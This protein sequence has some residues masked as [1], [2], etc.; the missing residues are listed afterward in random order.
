MTQ[1]DDLWKHLEESGIERCPDHDGVE[2]EGHGDESSIDILHSYYF[3]C[4]K[5]SGGIE[6]LN[7]LI[8]VEHDG[9]VRITPG[10][11]VFDSYPKMDVVERIEELV[12]EL[13]VALRSFIRNRDDLV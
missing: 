1:N 5:F 7:I 13:L 4:L 11:I 6:F 10:E 9:T 8:H 2:I 12:E 3:E